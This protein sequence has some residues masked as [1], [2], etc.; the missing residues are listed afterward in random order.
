MCV[1]PA[2]WAV[3]VS[4][5]AVWQAAGVTPDAVVGHSQ[6]EIAAA[7]VAG[8]LSLEDGARIV[9]L[10]SK[11]LRALS[12]AGGMVSVAEPAAAARDR[13]AA[14]GDRLSVAAV[15]GP[16]AT[17]VS[18]DP[19]ALD[20]LVAACAAAGVR[21]RRLPVDY[22][23][24]GAQV[25]ALREE[26]LAALDGVIPGPAV[27][28]M[29]SAMTG[30]WLDGL[31]AEAGYW[32]QSLR[33]PVEFGQAVRVLSGSGHGVFVELSPHP[34]LTAA[35]TATAEDGGTEPVVTGT[36][37]RDDGGPGRF[38]ASLAAVHV[39]GGRP[40]GPRSCPPGG[41]WTCPPTRSSGSGT[42]RRPWPP[43]RP[44]SRRRA[45]ARCGTRCSA[46]RWNWPAVRGTCSPVGCRCDPS[47][48][49]PAMSSA[50]PCWCPG[51]R[52]WKWRS[53]PGTRP[54]AAGSRT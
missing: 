37:R 50:R 21:A 25:E 52:S 22:A 20:E 33:S 34:V 40:T 46:R 16:E 13:I 11:A 6:G 1:Q 15:N 38:L 27:V 42:G 54:G 17:V 28:P 10:R 45:S 36:L 48:G 29:V 53:G 31:E 5:A 2:L 43:R 35:I 8:I 19:G 26:I 47:R 49:W 12:G 9:A 51:P 7:V 3:M 32:Y 18:G 41:G 39:R 44:T 30:E 14:W 4:L 24:H 23:S